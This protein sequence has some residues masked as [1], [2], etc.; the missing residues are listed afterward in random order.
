MYS[1][2]DPAGRYI[3]GAYCHAKLAAQVLTVFVLLARLEATQTLMRRAV[4]AGDGHINLTQDVWTGKAAHDEPC[5]AGMHLAKVPAKHLIDRLP[6]G[7][8]ANVDAELTHLIQARSG[9][10]EQTPGV[11]HGLVGLG[12]RILR[13]PSRSDHTAAIELGAGLSAEVDLIVG[14]EHH[15]RISID[16]LIEPVT[17]VKETP[18]PVCRGLRITASISISTFISGMASPL[19]IS[20]VATVGM[21]LRKRPTVL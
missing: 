10:V 21:P 9:F 16:S 14:L 20:P 4:C 12:C 17:R 2:S 13:G 5:G 15:T 3:A 6:I 18:A 11:L 1:R 7:A 8:I 19:T